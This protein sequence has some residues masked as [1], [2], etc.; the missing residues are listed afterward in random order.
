MKSM[1]VCGLPG[2]FWR[3]TFCQL[4]HNGTKFVTAGALLANLHLII[5][6]T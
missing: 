4:F 1:K 2:P 5:K 3:L 6:K